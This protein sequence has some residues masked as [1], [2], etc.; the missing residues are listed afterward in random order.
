MLLQPRSVLTDEALLPDRNEHDALRDE[1]LDL[2]Q[3][4]FSLLAV[5]LDELALEEA[6]DLGDRPVGIDALARGVRL[7]ASRR[8]A[9][10]AGGPDEDEVGPWLGQHEAHAPCVHHLHLAHARLEER[11]RSATIALE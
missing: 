5:H 6:L 1:P 9:G 11:R 3:Q 2:E 10:R 7:D 4:V 8:V